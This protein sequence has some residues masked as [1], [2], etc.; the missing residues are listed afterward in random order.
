MEFFCGFTHI[1]LL[2]NNIGKLC[3]RVPVQVYAQVMADKDPGLH[4][5][6]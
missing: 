5:A 6:R 4:T 2:E 3:V 1:I